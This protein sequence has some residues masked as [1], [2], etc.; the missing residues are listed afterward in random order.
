MGL[1]SRAPTIAGQPLVAAL[2][3]R[4]PRAAD[5]IRDQWPEEARLSARHGDGSSGDIAR[6]MAELARIWADEDA[7]SGRPSEWA[8]EAVAAMRALAA[9]PQKVDLDKGQLYKVEVPEN[10]VLLDWDRPWSEQPE[11]VQK[12]LAAYAVERPRRW[13]ERRVNRYQH[14]HRLIIDGEIAAVISVTDLGDAKGAYVGASIRRPDGSSDII[15]GGDLTLEGAK[16]LAERRTTSGE[17]IYRRLI[18]AHGSPEAASRWLNERGVKGLRYLDQGSRAAGE[19][20]HNFV[21]FDDQAIDVIETYYQGA[22]RPR[23]G[24][25]EARYVERAD[26]RYVAL[27]GGSDRLGEITA[28]IAAAI[29]REAA[30]IRL[31][32]GDARFGEAHIEAQRGEAIR[33]AGYAD[34]AEMVADVAAGFNRVFA[35]YGD[36]LVLAKSN[37]RARL[38]VLELQPSEDGRHWKVLTAGVFREGYLRGKRLLWE[39]ERRSGLAADEGEP[40]SMRGGQSSPKKL[41]QEA[42]AGN[43]PPGAVPGVPPGARAAPRAAVEIGEGIHRPV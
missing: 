35:S 17:T 15:P 6:R 19:G 9:A 21:V 33:A 24:Q 25:G 40:P 34:A 10:D 22:A 12:A 26:G 8:D 14:E 1:S 4:D 30:P 18:R 16:Q 27:E 31:P 36:R 39:A 28:E 41:S 7:A 43:A 32:E 13:E 2:G 38:A 3:I 11:A 20:S 29:G 37:G 23:I 42:A 5:F